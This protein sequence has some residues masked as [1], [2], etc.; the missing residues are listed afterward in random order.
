M[1]DVK[2]EIRLNKYLASCGIG[3]RRACDELIEGGRIFVNGEK[4]LQL[5]VRVNPAIDKVVYKG[6][7]VVPIPGKK[8]LAFHKSRGVIVTK[9]DPE[10]RTTVFHVLAKHGIND[11]GLNYVGRLDV[12]SEGLLLLTN[13]GDLIHRLTHPRY[14]I[15]KVY[16]VRVDKP[17][18]SEHC[19]I[20]KQDGV[21]SEGQVLH[22]GDI[23]KCVDRSADN[24]FWFYIDLY[25]GKN[26]QI[27][28]M[29]EALGYKVLR[30]VRIQFGPVSLSSL[31]VDGVR[32]L[33]FQEINGLKAAGFGPAHYF[34]PDGT[35]T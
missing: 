10:G 13:D 27:R 7:V 20:M 26:R 15:K 11:I 24:E 23:V 1:T 2:N 35:V 8:Y 9:D 4:V 34:K 5:G 22:A 17:I 14:H 30:L 3:S 6:V 19:N 28:R 12:N 33:T 25:E 32:E 29:L 18:T 31:S 21:E 16:D